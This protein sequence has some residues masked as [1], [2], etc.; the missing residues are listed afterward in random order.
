M[1]TRDVTFFVEITAKINAGVN[2]EDVVFAL[3][4]SKVKPQAGGMTV[5]EVTGYTTTGFEDAEWEG[6]VAT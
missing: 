6:P 2:S 5:G 3:D 1:E 4:I